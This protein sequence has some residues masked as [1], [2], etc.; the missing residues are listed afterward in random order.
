MTNVA[1]AA[2][3]FD[4]HE[5]LGLLLK[6][7]AQQSVPVTSVALVDSGTRPAA[8]VVAAADGTINY[9]RSEA[10]LGGAGGFA[11]AI[12]AALA[13]GADWIWLMDDDGHPEDARCLEVLLAAAGEHGLDI[14]S[15]LVVATE[16][17][18]RLSFNFRINGL[19]TNDRTRLEP[20]GYL[21]DMLHFFNGALI[22]REVFH[23]VGLPD[24]KFFI[25]GDEVDF[26]AKVKK[27]GLKYGTVATTA[28]RHPASWAEMKPIFRGFITPVIPEG[29]F[30]RY[31]YFRN[32][33]YLT[34][35]YRN[36]RWFAADIIGFPY[37]FLSVRD[38][39]GLVR[40]ARAY[41]AGFRGRG[42]GAPEELMKSTAR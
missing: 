42:F 15:P 3:T 24:L 20:L 22:R 35:R 7:L 40:W 39:V 23:T 33:G 27:A 18:N 21:P 13:S 29:D 2:V 31:C 30:K 17:P 28:V 19:L 36:L 12:L 14:V 38:G 1:V 16:D 34:R 4:R 5:E 32:R 10:N 6:G 26:L 37:Y 11:Y 25:R 9:L 41:S 8:D